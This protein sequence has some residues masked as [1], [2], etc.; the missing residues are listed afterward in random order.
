[1][2]SASKG[3]SL[4]GTDCAVSCGCGAPAWPEPGSILVL[5]YAY[6]ATDGPLLDALVTTRI[7]RRTLLGFR[8]Y[9]RT[10]GYLST[11]SSSVGFVITADLLPGSF[12]RLQFTDDGGMRLLARTSD[13]SDWIAVASDATTAPA[14]PVRASVYLYWAAPGSSQCPQPIS[15][16]SFTVEDEPEPVPPCVLPCKWQ[17][18]QPAP[19]TPNDYLVADITTGVPGSWHGGAWQVLKWGQPWTAGVNSPGAYAAAVESVEDG[20]YVAVQPG[21]VAI[22]A[23][24][25]YDPVRAPAFGA[26]LVFVLTTCIPAGTQLSIFVAN[27]VWSTD[28]EPSWTWTAPPG[29]DLCPGTCVDL[30]QLGTGDAFDNPRPR[31]SIGTLVTGSGRPVDGPITAFVITSSADASSAVTAMLPCSYGGL[32][33]SCL[34]FGFSIL[35]RPWPDCA[36]RIVAPSCKHVADWPLETVLL[37][38]ACPVRWLM[39]PSPCFATN[40]GCCP[41][42]CL[43]SLQL[44]SVLPAHTPI[45]AGGCTSRRPCCTRK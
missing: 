9:P 16:F 11:N 18:I 39:E 36:S 45:L 26:Q 4:G 35:C 42:C 30:T 10:E 1:M 31:A 21:Q 14:I 24:R 5:G 8:F 41:S 40:T 25:P 38:R 43:Q 27:P 22:L 29:A 2:W 23:Y 15:S 37:A 12:L 28:L 32:V 7:I 13:S 33:P 3:S 44:P 17:L 20:L 19:D 34:V 6:M